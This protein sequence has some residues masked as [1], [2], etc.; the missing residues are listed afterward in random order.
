MVYTRTMFNYFGSKRRLAKT[1]QP[2]KHD[3]IVEPFGGSAQYAVAWLVERPSLRAIVFDTDPLVIA[4][5]RRMLAATPAEILAWP[6]P[7]DGDATRD[8]IDQA[9]YSGG[10]C[11]TVTGRSPL[12]FQQSKARWAAARSAI[13][14]RIEW[15]LGDYRDAPDIEATWF[16]DPPYQHQGHRYKE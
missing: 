2:P 11:P 7:E 4:S 1:Y 15:H 13:G 8:Y 5:W 16:V 12:T 9:N 6:V 14:D 10:F 3:L